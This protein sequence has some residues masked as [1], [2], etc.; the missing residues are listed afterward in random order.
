MYEDM[1][2]NIKQGFEF[3]DRGIGDSDMIYSMMYVTMSLY[4]KSSKETGVRND[5]LESVNL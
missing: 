5:Y 1:E 2:A 3:L 4:R